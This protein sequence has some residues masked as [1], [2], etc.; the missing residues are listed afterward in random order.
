MIGMDD[1]DQT[2]RAVLPRSA[3]SSL[4]GLRVAFVSKSWTDACD[5]RIQKMMVSLRTYFQK[6][7]A[8]VIE[9]VDPGFEYALPCYYILSSA[10]ASSNLSRFDGIRYGN[11]HVTD[12][13]KKEVYAPFRSS[14]FGAEVKRRIMLGTYVLTEGYADQY[15]RKA[16]SA[17]QRI[18]AQTDKM[19]ENTDVFI[20]PVAAGPAFKLGEKS[21]DPVAMYQ[22]DTF[23]TY[24]N[25]AKIPA[26]ALPYW[27]DQF[28]T[29]PI[30][31]Q[32]HAAYQRDW[33]LLA[34]AQC[35][36][37]SHDH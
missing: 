21:S 8:T 33:N 25:L 27:D 37:E 17:R 14:R 32:M 23:T 4:S 19:F 31:F 9:D 1:R 35:Y 22:S 26:V 24:A 12:I 28:T 20:A 10:E 30:G 3:K 13:R 18:I 36:E 7:G 16:V 29:A 15:Y 2:T 5:L 11:E 6:H 34:A